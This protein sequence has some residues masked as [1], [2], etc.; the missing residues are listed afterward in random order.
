VKAL[1][2]GTHLGV[3]EYMQALLRVVETRYLLQRLLQERRAGLYEH[4][5][6]HHRQRRVLFTMFISSFVINIFH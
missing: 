3:Q 5:H 6:H 2:E 1:S 4:R